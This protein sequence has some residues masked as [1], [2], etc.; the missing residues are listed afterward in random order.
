MATNYELVSND[1]KVLIDFLINANSWIGQIE[2][3]YCNKIC[4]NR[5]NGKCLSG[6]DCELPHTLEEM[7]DLW[8]NLKSE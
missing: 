4:P 1:R 8:L 7:I 3:E 5:N 6:D 2:G